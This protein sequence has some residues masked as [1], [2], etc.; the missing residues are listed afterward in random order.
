IV[1]NNPAIE[2]LGQCL[3]NSEIFRRLAHHMGFTDPCFLETDEQIAAQAFVRCGAAPY[4]WERVR[5]T[6]W[7]R[8]DLPPTYAPFALGNFPTPSGRCEFFSSRL[9]QLGL[10]PV[11]DYVAPYEGPTSTPLLVQRYPLAIISPPARHFLNSS[12]VNVQSLRATEGEPWLEMHPQD[13]AARAIEDG[14]R[15]EVFNDRGSF[16]LRVRVN[17]RPRPGV[18]VALSIWW[19]KLAPDGKNANEVTHQHL[20]D[21]GRAAS[22]Y[23]CLVQVRHAS[24]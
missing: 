18:V 23:D 12:F 17:E 3:P 19:K 15:V 16:T 2:P 8:L 6:G 1:A 5:R 11:P 4:D 13:A 14:D 21:L 9:A 7:Q 10:D 20:T 22:F 24:R